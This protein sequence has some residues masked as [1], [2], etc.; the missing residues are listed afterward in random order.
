MLAGTV[1]P[2]TPEAPINAGRIIARPYPDLVVETE[3]G[4]VGLSDLAI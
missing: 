3:Y 1:Q 4:Q 2:D